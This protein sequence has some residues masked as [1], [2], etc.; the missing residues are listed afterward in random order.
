MKQ[1][2][3]GIQSIAH[4][5]QFKSQRRSP[6]FAM[7]FMRDHSLWTLIRMI[8]RWDDK[9]SLNVLCIR[10]REREKNLR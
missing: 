3:I 7:A 2:S 8:C 9:S 1:F 6:S 5:V 10:W 4:I